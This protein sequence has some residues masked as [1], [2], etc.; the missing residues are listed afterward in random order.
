M[1]SRGR[2]GDRDT[3]QALPLISLYLRA[4]DQFIGWRDSTGHGTTTLTRGTFYSRAA[5]ELVP[6]GWTVLKAV[7][8]HAQSGGDRR[9][10]DL[11]QAVFGRL[12]QTLVA[13]DSMYWAL[14]RAQDNDTAD[15]ALSAFDLAMLTLMGA[16]DASAR[17]AHWLLRLDGSDQSAAW[18][19]RAWRTRARGASTALD[20]VFSG[21]SH[22]HALTILTELRNTIHASPL[23]PLAVANSRRQ[24]TTVIELPP[25]AVTKLLSALTNLGGAARWGVDT[26]IRGRHHADPAQL[27]DALISTITTMLEAVMGTM[28][29]AELAGVNPANQPLPHARLSML[30]DVPSESLLWQLGL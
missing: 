16:V 19:N 26:H 22:L 18:L 20:A 24:V 5:V 4:Q 8:E 21:S 13:R 14:N 28:P 11:V 25:D 3:Q 2:R 12:Q 7:A 27:L 30:M 17:I 23:N 6:H 29:V 15:E 9:P 1:G 10:L